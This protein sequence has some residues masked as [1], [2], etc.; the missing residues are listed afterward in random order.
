MIGWH[1]EQRII[2]RALERPKCGRSD[3][4]R[5]IARDRLEN[6][7]YGIDP[8]FLQL[9]NG[10]EPLLFPSDNQRAREQRT[11]AAVERCLQQ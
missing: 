2:L 4:R 1:D 5:G 10:S 11:A 3:R 9:V 8:D 7:R 6:D